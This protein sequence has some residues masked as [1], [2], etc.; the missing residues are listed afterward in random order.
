MAERA[1]MAAAGVLA[2][3]VFLPLMAPDM[4]L[5]LAPSDPAIPLTPSARLLVGPALGAPAGAGWLGSTLLARLALA[6]PIGSPS[7]RLA[8]LALLAGVTAAMLT[9]A[10]YR[11]LSLSCPSALLGSVVAVTGTTSLALVTTGS[12]DAVLAPLVPGLLLCGL[13]W[14]E[15]R[16]LAALVTL[17]LLMAVAVGSYPAIIVICGAVSLSLAGSEVDGL[18]R[19]PR[20]G[21]PPLA[22]LTL[23][24]VVVGI[25]HRVAAAWTTWRV[26]T[27][28]ISVGGDPAAAW[29]WTVPFGA[30]RGDGVGDRLSTVAS[31]AAGELWLPAVLLAAVGIVLLRRHLAGRSLVW[32]WGAAVVAVSVWMPSTTSDGSRVAIIL[33]WLLVGVGLDWAWRSTARAARISAIAMALFLVVTATMGASGTRSW[34]AALTGATHLDRV[35]AAAT[36]GPPPLLVTEGPVLD[37]AL[38]G[39]P[40]RLVTRVPLERSA[41]KQLHDAGRP[42]IAFEGARGLLQ[43]VGAQFETMPI[44]AQSVTVPQLLGALPRGTIVAAAAGP[45]LVRANAPG[46]GPLFAAA[47]GSTDLF[48]QRIGAYGVIGLIGGGG[49]ALEQSSSDAITLE[50][51]VGD[52][53]GGFPV[54]TMASLR[55]VSDPGGAQVELNGEIAARAAAGLALV[56]I[57]PDGQ[58]VIAVADEF[59]QGG[60]GFPLAGV[61]PPVSQLVGWEPCLILPVG[62][63]VDAGAAAV[64]GGVGAWLTAPGD[65]LTMYTTARRERPL[66]VWADATEIAGA[67]QSSYRPD[68]DEQWAALGTQQDRDQMPPGV[69]WSTAP[70]VRRVQVARPGAAAIAFGETP[71]VAYVRYESSDPTR[72]GLELCGTVSGE[73]LFATGSPPVATVSVAQLDTFGWG[74]HDPEQDGRGPFR[75][76]DGAETE[77]LV[78]LTRT[79]QLRVELDASA[80]AADLSDDP[81][82]ITLVVNGQALDVQPMARGTQTHRWLVPAVRWKTGMNR[83]GLRVSSA[84]SPAALGLSDDQRSLGIAVRRLEFALVE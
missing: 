67:V 37:R 16:R 36:A 6:L 12:A 46:T 64:A 23:G 55:V 22:A 73:P 68:V 69:D 33:S 40:S 5:G 10:F 17:L 30:L 57:A 83:V 7:T 32:A 45:R 41:V 1:W 52:A 31:L 72:E 13:W 44:P 38:G 43:Q 82:T 35:L 66:R 15:T 9:F 76:S 77:L 42:M 53:V 60:D 75:W 29:S 34:S 49:A 71:A 56:A 21:W 18:P 78:Q 51:A 47:G 2:L 48:G 24:A 84:V 28:A 20:G 61:D 65:Q 59:D 8:V 79:G 50:L 58:L 26:A 54:R 62:E 81:V 39:D 19:R 80:A 14:T 74:W 27:E 4:G 70:V 3:G 63:W 11:R 25:L